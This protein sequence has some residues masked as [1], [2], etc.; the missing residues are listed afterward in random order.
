MRQS[1]WIGKV[2]TGRSSIICL[3]GVKLTAKSFVAMRPR[4][5]LGWN[6]GLEF[7]AEVCH[8]WKQFQS[9]WATEWE[10]DCLFWK[11]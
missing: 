2:S 9:S 8:C 6:R 11:L 3:V 4:T 10:G 1:I 7:P 5:V